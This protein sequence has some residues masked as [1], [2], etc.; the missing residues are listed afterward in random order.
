[1]LSATAVE[2]YRMWKFK[3]LA[4]KGMGYPHH[5]AAASNKPFSILE[6]AS[7][8][9]HQNPERLQSEWLP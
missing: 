1:M 3:D 2:V 4:W 5:H 9:S 8:V 6:I 7:V